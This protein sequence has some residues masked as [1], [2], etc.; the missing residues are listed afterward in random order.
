MWD[1]IN[2]KIV[3]RNLETGARLRNLETGACINCCT[4]G[5]TLCDLALVLYVDVFVSLQCLSIAEDFKKQKVIN[6]NIKMS[7]TN[8]FRYVCLLWSSISS[9]PQT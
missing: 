4:I 8:S 9:K 3:K 2:S 6:T 7:K 1:D 5:K